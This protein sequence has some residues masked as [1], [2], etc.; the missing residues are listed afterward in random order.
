MYLK[1][2]KIVTCILSLSLLGCADIYKQPPPNE[3]TAKIDFNFVLRLG[4]GTGYEI[5]ADPIRCDQ[6]KSI[7]GC[8]A[9]NRKVTQTIP[10]GKI[11]TFAVGHNTTFNR[12]ADAISFFPRKNK[13]YEVFLYESSGKCSYIITDENNKPVKLKI[14]KR[15]DNPF[16]VFPTCTDHISVKD[17]Q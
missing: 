17:L 3:A 10:A 6:A 9:G 4:E 5:Y 16:V 7:Q 11:F 15:D 1:L 8:R 12:C 13:H 2:L 14:R